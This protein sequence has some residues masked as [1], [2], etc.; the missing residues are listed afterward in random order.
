[1]PWRSIRSFQKSGREIVTSVRA[2][3]PA[4]AL[5]PPLLLAAC[6]GLVW[7]TAAGAV[8]ARPRYLLPVM[9]ATAIHIGV[10]WS[11]LWSRARVGLHPR[12]LTLGWHKVAKD[13]DVYV[14]PASHRTSVTTYGDVLA[15]RLHACLSKVQ[16]RA[17]E[18]RPVSYGTTRE[19]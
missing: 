16:A 9:A 15:A 17:P 5:L 8:Y 18:F 2:G 6:L 13:V 4:P 10:A 14:I 19:E 1:M 11:H 7:A 3:R 12:D